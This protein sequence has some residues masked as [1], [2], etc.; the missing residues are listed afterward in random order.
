MPRLVSFLSF[1]FHTEKDVIEQYNKPENA[2]THS[3]HD[4]ADFR[5]NQRTGIYDQADLFSNL[6]DDLLHP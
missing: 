3:R 1:I 4:H 5:I 2:K 6:V